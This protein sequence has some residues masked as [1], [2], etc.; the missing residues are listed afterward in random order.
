MIRENQRFLNHLNMVLDAL[1]VFLS[2]P[3][4]FWLRFTLF[5]GI[6]SVPLSRYVQAAVFLALGQVLI[7]AFLG[8]YESVR[9]KRL[10][11]DFGEMLFTHYGVSGPLILS[12]S[13]YVGG[14]LKSGEL[15]LEIDLK[16][17]LDEEQLDQRVR[18]DFEENL[19][20]QF[21]NAVGKLF[22]SKLIPVMVELSG[23]DPEKKVNVI[24]KEERLGF[25]RLIKHLTLTLTGL[26]D[27]NEAVITRGGVNTKEVDPKT[28]ESKYIRGL[29]FAGEVLDLDAL[30]G[31][32][33]LQIAWSTG[34][35]AG[36]GIP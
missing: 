9:K 32:F 36:H 16:P 19:N 31:G 28:M 17:A 3:A 15:R 13:S 1:L 10:Y 7:Y 35:A 26:R 22:P 11:Q 33:N 12:A 24:S 6:P 2:L 8:L 14:R 25:V 5:P 29:Y 30:T 34:Y 21:K 27:Y 4:S 23:I 18:R 20:R